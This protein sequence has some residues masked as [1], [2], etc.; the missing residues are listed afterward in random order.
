MIL[1]YCKINIYRYP[2]YALIWTTTPWTLA[3]NKAICY[4]PNLSYS[5]IE[6][7]NMEGVYLI[8]TDLIQPFTQLASKNVK[9]LVNFKGLYKLFVFNT[10]VH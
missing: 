1:H 8:A 6:I 10:H 9:G 4:N 7:D 2:I 5:L 3:S